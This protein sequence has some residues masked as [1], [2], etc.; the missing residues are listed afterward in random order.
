MSIDE[1][2]RQ[3]LL[4]DTDVIEELMKDQQ[5]LF[6]RFGDTYR[7]GGMSGFMIMVTIVIFVVSGFMIWSAYE[8]MSAERLED[9]VFWG[10]WFIIL[11]N[12]QGAMKLWTWMESNRN[13]V[14][15]ELKRVEVELFRLKTRIDA[16][17]GL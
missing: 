16:E 11:L 15:R 6:A 8:F 3:E 13:S 9:R 14:I 7:A 5:G 10:V 12:A 4:D 1:R 2:I 17:S